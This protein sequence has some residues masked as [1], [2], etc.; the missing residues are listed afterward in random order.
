MLQKLNTKV[1]KQD[2]FKYDIKLKFGKLKGGYKS[3]FGGWVSIIINLIMG[4]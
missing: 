3:T 2:L 1:K 4:W